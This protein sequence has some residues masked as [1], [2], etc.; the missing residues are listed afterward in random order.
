M[1]SLPS[2][3]QAR[4]RRWLAAIAAGDP[5]ARGYARELA[6][7]EDRGAAMVAARALFLVRLY[8]DALAA[9]DRW[10][11]KHPTDGYAHRLRYSFLERLGFQE[12]RAAVLEDLLEV[13][14]DRRV[15][16]AAALCFGAQHR[17]A[18][19]M[20]HVERALAEEPGAFALR[21]MAIDAAVEMKDVLHVERAASRALGIDAE[22]SAGYDGLLALG[23]FREAE[24]LAESRPKSPLAIAVR[25][26]LAAFRGEWEAAYALAREA[27]ELDRGCARATTVALAASVGAGELGRAERELARREGELEPAAR[28]WRAELLLARGELDRAAAELAVVRD[29]VPDY[30]AAKLLW[31]LVRGA[32]KNER[33]VAGAG[34][35]GLLEGQLGAFGVTLPTRDGALDGAVDAEALRVAARDVLTRMAG[36]RTPSPSVLEDGALRRV[37]VPPSARHRVRRLQHLAAHLGLARARTLVDEALAEIGPHPVAECYA[38]ELD[39]WAGDYERARARFADIIARAERTTWAWIGLGASHT[40]AGRPEVGL[41]LL[42]EGVAVVG[43]RGA[44]LP[45]YRGEALLRL[46][47]FDEAAT[48]LARA[49]EAHPTRISAWLL[50]ILVAAARGDD[51]AREHAFTHLH[52]AGGL[53]ADAIAAAGIDGGWPG[54]LAPSDQVRAAEAALSLMRGNRASSCPLWAAPT[55]GA[56]RSVIAGRVVETDA[57]VA[58]ELRAL[59]RLL[60]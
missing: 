57:W 14:D 17:P 30:V 46:G 12:E 1:A 20:V 18:D 47:R 45:A 51:D 53:L 24:R 59:E 31:V 11:A 36:N 16:E 43:R 8:P 13:A 19:V 40:L 4:I 35:E 21:T 49:I 32:Q 3:A 50:S 6:G 27:L 15:H 48:E 10:I 54:R 2:A 34:Y 56:M 60:R 37:H 25:A 7:D 39:L 28:V 58:D 23:C 5:A 26:E 41:R 22:R 55:T 44:S 29:A 38:A 42:D 9:L 33:D 52:R